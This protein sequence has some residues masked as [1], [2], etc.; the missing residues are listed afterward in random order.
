MANN[1][2][3]TRASNPRALQLGL[4]KILDQMGKDYQGLGDRIFQEIKTD[5]AFFEIMQQAG[6]GIAARKGEGEVID[7]DSIDQSW[8]FRVPVNT[9]QK[10]SRITREGLRDNKYEALLPKMAKQQVRGLAHARDIEQARILNQAF[11]GGVTYGDGSV[12]C[13]TTHATQSGQTNSNRLTVDADLSEESLENSVLLIDNFILDEGLQSDY[14]PKR[15]IVPTAL[16]FE[17]KRILKNPMRPG[18]ADRD[19]NV[20][21]MEGDIPE[22]V[23]WKRLSDTDAF[24]VQTDADEGL[25]LVRR[26]GI[27]TMEGKDFETYDSKLTAAESYAVSVGDHRCIVGTPGA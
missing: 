22:I 14:T 9:Y 2:R 16:R 27:F 24:F 20:L 5:K 19:I 26:E 10:S 25:I 15:L 12:A 11:T 6:M 8:V 23:V 13:S 18:T 7:W 3:I 4:D 17:A 21:N 1:G